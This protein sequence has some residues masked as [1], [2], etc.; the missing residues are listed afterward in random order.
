[1][2]MKLD[3]RIKYVMGYDNDSSS[4]TWMNDRNLCIQMTDN[5]FFM[6]PFDDKNIF[7]SH[8]TKPTKY[9]TDDIFLYSFRYNEWVLEKTI[10]N[11]RYIE[12]EECFKTMNEHLSK[13]RS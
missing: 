10:P 6:L 7:Y 9:Y 3:N 8:N 2:K 4:K 5:R 11:K 12:M 13:D 1:M